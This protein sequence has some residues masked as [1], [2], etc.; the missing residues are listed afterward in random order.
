VS[1]RWCN[2]CNSLIEWIPDT[3]SKGTKL[4][5]VGLLL[6]I[7]VLQYEQNTRI[8]PNSAQL[9]LQCH[10]SFKFLN[11]SRWLLLPVGSKNRQCCQPTSSCRRGVCHEVP[12]VATCFVVCDVNGN[13][14]IRVC[15]HHR[16]I[17]QVWKPNSPAW[18]HFTV[19]GCFLPAPCH[20]THC[21]PV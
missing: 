13:I 10:A 11:H 4:A 17:S 1:R 8:L 19:C 16:V 2:A 7:A 18:T 6:L 5:D 12:R 9:R 14:A 20:L 15:A 3:L 21:R